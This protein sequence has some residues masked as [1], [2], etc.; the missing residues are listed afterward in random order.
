MATGIM[1]ICEP[2]GPARNKQEGR[3]APLTENFRALSDRLGFIYCDLLEEMANRGYNAEDVF[4]VCDDHWS[5]A[6]N[7]IAADLLEPFVV[8]AFNR[9]GVK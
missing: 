2:G 4:F 8:E 7:R 3:T 1:D 6:G 9:A 5:P